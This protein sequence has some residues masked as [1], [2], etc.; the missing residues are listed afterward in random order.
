MPSSALVL[1]APADALYMGT[2]L[3]PL[4]DELML[5]LH[6]SFVAGAD[7]LRV[8]A[9]ASVFQWR[10]GNW[11]L[12]E[13]RGHF[14]IF[15]LTDAPGITAEFRL[16]STKRFAPAAFSGEIGSFHLEYTVSDWYH[17]N[18]WWLPR[19]MEIRQTAS[20][21]SRIAVLTLRQVRK[22]PAEIH[23]E[24]P[25]G[26]PVADLRDI[27]PERIAASGLLFVQGT[28]Y[29]YSWTGRLPERGVLSAV[30]TATPQPFV[31]VG[32][33]QQASRRS[34]F[35]LWQSLVAISLIVLGSIWYLR[36]K[37]VER[38]P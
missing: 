8:F 2:P 35:P 23:I 16:D 25:I 9:P 38:K 34:R 30:G 31:M 6:P 11:D 27:P 24:L 3:P 4:P 17:A 12:S 1:P 20:S 14:V 36:L 33:P 22:T 5:L 13:K 26:T 29:H 37:R 21:G 32:A 10:K 19:R 15:R 7:P 28:T 18:D